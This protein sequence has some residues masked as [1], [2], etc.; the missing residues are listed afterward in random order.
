MVN[1]LK[2][3]FLVGLLIL[4]VATLGA[5]TNQQKNTKHSTKTGD[6]SS[7]SGEIIPSENEK[8]DKPLSSTG[9]E[10]LMSVGINAFALD[11]YA[12]LRDSK[13]G[14][15]FLSPY[16][17]SSAFAMTY[18]GARGNTKKQMTKTL[19]FDVKPNIHSAFFELERSLTSIDD[20]YQ[21]RIANALWGQKE[22]SFSLDF[23]DLIQEYY[24]AQLKAV[25]F[26]DA[27]EETRKTINKWTATKTEQK[28]KELLKPSILTKQTKLVLTNAIYFNGNWQ[29]SFNEEDTS[30]LPFTVSAK[31]TVNV[32]TMYQQSKFNYMENQDVQIVELP[33]R[34][35]QLGED[36]GLS[37]LVILPKKTDGIS[38]VE[39]KLKEFEP[40]F[41]VQN[42]NEFAEKMVNIYLPKFKVES[43]FQLR[44]T[45][46]K[47]GTV[48]AFDS[49]RANF[50]G[51][52]NGKTKGLAITSVLHKT[53]V[54][55]NEKGTEA[56]AATAIVV[57]RG[58]MAPPIEFRAD[59][60]F[61]F[62]IRDNVSG[63]ILFLGRVVEP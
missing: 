20:T 32:P 14:N 18:A 61:I 6:S 46:G 16:G 11:L 12:E 63:T 5:C 35:G 62:L 44:E 2:Q 26:K 23:I 8:G 54:D 1:K 15:L 38:L 47:L 60:P 41:D 22:L 29:S 34:K 58:I 28:I 25:D 9:N 51:F 48:D 42:S 3:I 37:M 4:S 30:D 7:V 57:S 43:A 19:H 21:L 45:L 24:G 53:F 50:S 56:A 17:I 13:K 33:Y 36:E 55:V 52:D 27:T 10:Q 31:T 59:H 40:Y 49:E 39:G